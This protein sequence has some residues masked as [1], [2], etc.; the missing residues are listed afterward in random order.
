MTVKFQTKHDRLI[1]KP[2][3][4]EEQTV[5]GRIIIPDLGYE[6]SSIYQ[7]TAAG[8]GFIHPLTGQFVPT[9]YKVGDKVY[10]TKAVLISMGEID[11]VEYF[12]TRD[13]EPLGYVLEDVEEDANLND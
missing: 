7:V 8:P 1:L 5:G 4:S 6:K 2:I 11:G 3:E 13:N 12:A 9:Q 10:C